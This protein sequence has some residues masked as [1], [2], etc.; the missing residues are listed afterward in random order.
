MM[1]MFRVTSYKLQVTSPPPYPP[2]KCGGRIALLLIF[3]LLFVSIQ[4]QS[5]VIISGENTATYSYRTEDDVNNNY[6][7]NEF[8]FRLDQRYF[9]FG[10]SFRAELPRYDPIEP[11]DILTPSIIHTEWV[12]R[13]V[14]LN[15]DN[16]FL[17]AG[18]LEESFGSGIVFRSW[19]DRELDIEN[20]LEGAQAVFTYENFRLTGVY[21]NLREYEV[22]T[23]TQQ[24]NKNDLVIGGDLEYRPFSFLNFGISVLEYK[25]ETQNFWGEFERYTHFNTFGGRIGVMGDFYDINLEH[26][27]IKRFHDIV[28]PVSEGSAFY[29]TANFYVGDF[30]LSGGYKRYDKYSLY[31]YNDME[32]Y[33]YK[34]FHYPLADLPTLNNYDELLTTYTNKDYEEGF[35]GEIRFIPNF[36]NEILVNYAESWGRE[37]DTWHRNIYAEYKKNFSNFNFTFDIEFLDKE[38]PHLVNNYVDPEHADYGKKLYSGEMWLRPSLYFD[39]HQFFIPTSI[40][41]AY[42]Y[43]EE[44]L[45]FEFDGDFKKQYNNKPQL[46][47][48]NRFTDDLSL[49]IIFENEFKNISEIDKSELF[50]GGEI[51][52]SILNHTDLKLFIGKELGGKVCRNGTCVTQPPF[53]GVR[54]GL[55]TRF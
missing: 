50:I 48:E 34:E 35:M 9:S 22:F 3:I 14:Q 37:K 11:S 5:G 41:L 8:K 17:K 19:Y 2:H 31:V 40:T 24:T 49:A 23:Q 12:D 38:Y 55:T 45:T 28:A 1:K 33:T 32:T 36:D 44:R 43:T 39:F 29:S 4:A 13:Y 54:L 26:S 46:Q 6:F 27:L 53:E 10:M 47:I 25:Q 18:T 30:T 51:A 16:F 20:R 52:Y 15:L 42:E 21:G 7:E